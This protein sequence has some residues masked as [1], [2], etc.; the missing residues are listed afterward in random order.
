[1][2]GETMLGNKELVIANWQPS[3]L[4]KQHPTNNKQIEKNNKWQ[5]IL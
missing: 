4:V 2:L 1:M 3:M 5:N